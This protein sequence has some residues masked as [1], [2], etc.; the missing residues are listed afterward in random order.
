MI[1][2]KRNTFRAVLA[3][4]AATVLIASASAAVAARDATNSPPIIVGPTLEL[5]DNGVIVK[6]FVPPAGIAVNDV[7][8]HWATPKV[9]A[10]AIQFPPKLL[11]WSKNGS[12]VG[13]PLLAPCKVNDV[14][15]Y[16]DANYMIRAHRASGAPGT[17]WTVKGKIVK[18]LTPPAGT[19]DFHFFWL[20]S[21]KLLSANWS[22]NGRSVFKIPLKSNVTVNDAH[23]IMP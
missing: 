20:K 8:L 4:V 2:S 6:T 9:C 11:Q 17:G 22:L 5:T 7:D 23:L 1:K 13:A 18:T 16:W 14:E 12:L 10:R 21:G 3:L 15:V 19:N